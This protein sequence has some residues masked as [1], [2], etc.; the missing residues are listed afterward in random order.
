MSDESPDYE[1]AEEALDALAEIKGQSV[2]LAED[3]YKFL[4]HFGQFWDDGYELQVELAEM[5]TM[6]H[7][8]RAITRCDPWDAIMPVHDISALLVEKYDREPHTA[9]YGGTGFTLD[10]QHEGNIEILGEEID[11]WP[12]TEDEE[13]DDD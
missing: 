10:A 9:S 4:R 6:A 7:E 13:A 5:A 1:S 11:G 2:I 12:S 3:A 8:E